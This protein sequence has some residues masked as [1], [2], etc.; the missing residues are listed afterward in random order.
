MK[1]ACF[2]GY[3]DRGLSLPPHTHTQFPVKEAI[4]LNEYKSLWFHI[5]PDKDKNKRAFYSDTE[6]SNSIIHVASDERY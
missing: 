3:Q 1:V 5:L 2:T 6:A 4:S